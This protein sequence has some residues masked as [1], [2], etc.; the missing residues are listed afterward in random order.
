MKITELRC[1][2]CNGTLKIDEKNPNIAECEYCRTRYT[3]EW[4]NENTRLTEIP[5][6]HY[7]PRPQPSAGGGIQYV[8]WDDVVLNEHLDFLPHYQG[9]K[10]PEYRRQ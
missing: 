9:L 6:I 1:T 10:T 4:D 5:Q 2:A 7:M 3:I 8:N